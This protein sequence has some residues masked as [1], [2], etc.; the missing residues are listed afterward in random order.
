MIRARISGLITVSA[1]H[2]VAN[3][4]RIRA[5][6]SGWPVQAGRPVPRKP[7]YDPRCPTSRNVVPSY[8]AGVEIT[9]ARCEPSDRVRTTT[10]AAREVLDELNK[11]C[12]CHD[13]HN[14]LYLAQSKRNNARLAFF[15]TSV[16]QIFMSAD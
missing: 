2:A 8:Q 14:R 4:P 12:R 13:A 3:F 15:L 16:L 9:A 10:C 1:N 6:D 5:R 11:R 7:L